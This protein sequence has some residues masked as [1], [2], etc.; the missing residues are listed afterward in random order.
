MISKVFVSH[1][2]SEFERVGL[3]LRYLLACTDA[4]CEIRSSAVPG[5]TA[6]ATRGSDG[7]RDELRAAEVVVAVVTPAA[8]SS[9]QFAIELG[10]AWALEKSI[11]AL[12]DPQ[13]TLTDLPGALREQ[14]AF[15]L[16]GPEAVR[17]LAQYVFPEHTET[18]EGE[19]LLS[20]MFGE[21]T[22]QSQ[23]RRISLPAGDTH[24]GMPPVRE[25]TSV[26]DESDSGVH[27]Q[28]AA[29]GAADSGVQ[30]AVA[31]EGASDNGAGLSAQ[32]SLGA[33]IA[34]SECSF[35]GKQGGDFANELDEPFGAFVDALGG[36]WSDLRALNDLDLWEGATENLLSAL[37]TEMS[38]VVRWYEFG[39]LLSTV[40]NIGAR[41]LP[42]GEQQ[43]DEALTSRLKGH[44]DDL[45]RLAGEL[46]L[47][48]QGIADIRSMLENLTG[49]ESEK[50]YTNVARTLQVAREL[51]E[52]AD[53]VQ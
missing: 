12:T 52:A 22:S 39:G 27:L 43:D 45:L 26:S 14:P 23:A 21:R 38:S 25:E 7:L 13:L 9:P 31:A 50:D 51:A 28:A 42:E 18:E 47:P 8:L 24:Q 49:P 20:S 35:D 46:G 4:P 44:M 2:V 48:E 36:S 11:V 19:Q 10:A 29:E 32:M 33:G 34:F 53:N 41:G 40:L 16:E 15:A 37:P 1:A 3:L 6:D 30:P 5:H 17:E